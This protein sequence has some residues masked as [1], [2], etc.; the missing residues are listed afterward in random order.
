MSFAIPYD[1][2]V[3]YKYTDLL[4]EIIDEQ[5]T[6]KVNGIVFH[7]STE[8]EYVPYNIIKYYKNFL[9]KNY[10]MRDIIGWLQCAHRFEKEYPKKF[11]KFIEGEI[12]HFGPFEQWIE[13]L[14]ET[15][16]I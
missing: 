2:L 8:N 14:G 16:S 10:K 3:I 12:N 6:H 15:L 4:N 11:E 9:I 5:S 7:N 13:C 1:I